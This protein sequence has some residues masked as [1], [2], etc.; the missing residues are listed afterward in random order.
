M[1]LY[2]LQ[3]SARSDMYHLQ[4]YIGVAKRFP[5]G[6]TVIVDP[7]RVVETPFTWFDRELLMVKNEQLEKLV[8]VGNR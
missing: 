4:D 3:E 8:N 5:G 1:L 2:D 6:E 7:G